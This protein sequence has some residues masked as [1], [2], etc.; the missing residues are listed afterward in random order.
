MGKSIDDTLDKSHADAA[1]PG[2]SASA[3]DLLAMMAG[4]EIDRLLAE[5]EIQNPADVIQEH[6]SETPKDHQGE[7]LSLAT[8]AEE[9]SALHVSSELLEQ[10]AL[11]NDAASELTPEPVAVSAAEHKEVQAKPV[12]ETSAEHAEHPTVNATTT[13]DIHAD[14]HEEVHATATVVHAADTSHKPATDP[15]A[16]HAD[17]KPGDPATVLAAVLANAENDTDTEPTLPFYLK[18]L[19]WINAPM[20]SLPDNVRSTL[21]KVGLLTLF[22][23]LAVLL[24]VL[25][26]RKHKG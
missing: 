23:A 10:A 26:F 24:Y 16:T 1:M 4:E 8:T 15:H 6:S 19:E 5:A 25:I 11:Q 13:P 12:H 7:D 17:A 3:D 14:K 20:A 21:G 9:K 18:P 2:A 22:N